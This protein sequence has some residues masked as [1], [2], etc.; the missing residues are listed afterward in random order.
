M[1]VKPDIFDVRIANLLNHLTHFLANPIL[2]ALFV[3]QIHP[4][5]FLVISL[6]LSHVFQSSLIAL[7]EISIDSH[8]RRPCHRWLHLP[9]QWY[10]PTDLQVTCN[11]KASICLLLCDNMLSLTKVCCM[12]LAIKSSH[13]ESSSHPACI[14]SRD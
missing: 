12:A 3:N 7:I 2:A 10:A 9:D 13:Y 6:R 5:L 4:V 11:R 14:F 8:W 1:E